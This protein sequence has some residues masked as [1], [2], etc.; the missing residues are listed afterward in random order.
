MSEPSSS[1]ELPTAHA[2]D[3]MSQDEVDAYWLEHVYQPNERQLTLR[4]VLSGM[5]LGGVLAV[6]NLYI[7]LKIGWS[8][9][10]A[11][12]S[13]ILA[14]AFF[15][16]MELA[17]IVKQEF[18]M[19]ENNTVAS[20]ASAAGYYCSAGM[21]SAIPALYITTQTSLSWWQLAFWMSA[22]SFVGVVMAVPMRRQMIDVD[23][24]KFP[25]GTAC[26]ETIKS[27]H[28]SAAEAMA[29][30]KALLYGGVV[31]ALAEI[32]AQLAAVGKV[33]NPLHW[34]DFGLLQ[35]PGVIAGRKL[36]SYAIA[37]PTSTLLYASG[38]IMG[39][40]VG[41]SMG[42]AAVVL[43][44]VGGPWLAAHGIVN[45]GA[46]SN[47]AY[48]SVLAWAV[49]P[50]VLGALAASL[51]QF[52]LKW[53]SILQAFGSLGR[54]ARSGAT[55][56]RMSAVE[57]PSSWFVWGMAAS[58]VFV[59]IAAKVIFD[60]PVWMSVV[61][62]AFSFL[63]AIVACRATGET[64]VTPIGPLGKITQLLFAGIRP[65]HYQTNL[66]TASITAG[67]ASHSADLLTDLK[68]GYL[69]GGAP[70]RQFVAQFMGIIAGAMF[71]VPAYKLVVGDGEKI[72]SVQLPAPAAQTWAVVA[73]LLAHGIESAERGPAQVSATTVE[74]VALK[75]RPPKMALGDTLRIKEG[76]NAGEYK[77]V[78]FERTTVILDRDLPV[79][80]PDASGEAAP[81]KAEVVAPDGSLRGGA[82][83][84][85]AANTTSKPALHFVAVPAGLRVNDYV[86]GQKD[87]ETVFHQ[88]KGVRGDVAMIDHA[89]M[90]PGQG[91]VDVRVTKLTLPPYAGTAVIIAVL[92]GIALTLLEIYGPKTWRHYLP[93]VTGMGIGFII[94][95]HDSI[96][97]SIGAIAAYIL[98]KAAPKVE[99]RYNVAASSGMIAGSSIMGLLLIIFSEVAHWLQLG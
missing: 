66:M 6:A 15:K 3:N 72:G 16:S 23:R 50:G 25:S 86:S 89:L 76:P 32:P 88:I 38:A 80:K 71:C 68:T 54:L 63:L 18:T 97:M 43:Y 60:I 92:L 47:T 53:R 99:E 51:L 19:L 36:L 55:P 44:G 22:V 14:F 62:V 91:N 46:D 5:L 64:D 85:I 24:L 90:V 17:G 73:D 42:I 39:I 28:H 49:W 33:A 98:A 82:P 58:T 67:A 94:A 45:L 2:L 87:G 83:V 74:T 34:K 31:A 81:F 13:T 69:L 27:M 57:V 37:L 1:H 65:G 77:I 84:A 10:M 11:I 75:K 78:G 70:R 29:K 48:K 7:G 96:A 21:V 59:S 12:T 52:G 9:G 40:R 30:A 93:S 4:A 8:M 41:L 20:A 56:S 35:L 61:A 79:A 26:A 95:C